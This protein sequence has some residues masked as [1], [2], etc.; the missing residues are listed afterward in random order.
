MV[1]TNA[2][3]SDRLY[4]TACAAGGAE[5]RIR[6]L[7]WAGDNI[8]HAADHLREHLAAGDQPSPL[9]ELEVA[10]PGICAEEP[11]LKLPT[12]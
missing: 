2:A 7:A 8:L 11:L 9:R 3:M 4:I 5:T 1:H 10:N 6:G 12:G